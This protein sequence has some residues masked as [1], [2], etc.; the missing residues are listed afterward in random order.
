MI[1]LLMDSC[2]QTVDV[3][4]LASR[5]NAGTVALRTM[6]SFDRDQLYS[7]TSGGSRIEP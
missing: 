7:R 1:A 3:S 4:E 5:R 6:S 2:N